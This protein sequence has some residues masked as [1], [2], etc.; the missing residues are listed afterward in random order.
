MIAIKLQKEHFLSAS[1]AS[2]NEIML[3]VKER[4]CGQVIWMGRFRQSTTQ[5]KRYVMGKQYVPRRRCTK[6]G[7]T[8]TDTVQCTQRDR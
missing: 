2:S 5:N 3:N 7:T 8:G 1:A 6:H 4:F